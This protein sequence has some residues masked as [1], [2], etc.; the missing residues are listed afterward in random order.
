M[1]PGCAPVEITVGERF[2]IELPSGKGLKLTTMEF[3]PVTGP[4]EERACRG[5][6]GEYYTTGGYRSTTGCT[7][8]FS[9]PELARPEATTGSPPAHIAAGLI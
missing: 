7:P 5:Q 9:S 8:P 3:R 6:L 2:R 1:R 4:L